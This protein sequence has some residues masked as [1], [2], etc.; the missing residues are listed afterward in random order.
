MKND[1]YLKRYLSDKRRFADLINGFAGDGR[2]LISA[3]DLSELGS[4]SEST[5]TQK[6]R[7]R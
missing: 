6:Y 2:E 7:D 5:R 3:T 4:Q 1:L